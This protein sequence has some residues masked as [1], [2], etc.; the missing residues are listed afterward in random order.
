M[1]E[2]KDIEIK[3]SIVIELKSKDPYDVNIEFKGNNNK[4][5]SGVM[6]ADNCCQC[7]ED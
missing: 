2:K 6:N 3:G 7:V 4:W 1:A 5:A